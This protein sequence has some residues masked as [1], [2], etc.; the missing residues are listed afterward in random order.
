MAEHESTAID[1]DHIERQTAPQQSYTMRDVGI[2]IV[3]AIV[4]MAIV[5][6]VPVLTHL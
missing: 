5:F 4:G 3:V 2:G 1:T 6:G